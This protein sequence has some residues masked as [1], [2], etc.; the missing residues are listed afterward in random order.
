[1]L[2]L[3]VSNKMLHKELRRR[4]GGVPENLVKKAQKKRLKPLKKKNIH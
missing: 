3:F 4:G 1:M 2:W